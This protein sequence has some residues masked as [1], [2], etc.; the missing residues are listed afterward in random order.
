MDDRKTQIPS[1]LN[2]KHFLMAIWNFSLVKMNKR[3]YSIS[4][5]Y[6]KFHWTAR[7]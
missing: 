4:W 5:L 2:S 6:E 3:I 1:L 7:Y